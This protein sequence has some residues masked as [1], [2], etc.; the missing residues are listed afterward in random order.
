MQKVQGN[1]MKISLHIEICQKEGFALNLSTQENLHDITA[2]F[3]EGFYSSLPTWEEYQNS[4]ALM[5]DS[6]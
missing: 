1:P 6:Y 5:Q 4:E 2:D 3:E